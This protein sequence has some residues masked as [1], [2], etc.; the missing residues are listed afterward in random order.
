[1][2]STNNFTQK[3]LEGGKLKTKAKKD[4]G[5]LQ[6]F[7]STGRTNL[8]CLWEQNF[9]PYQ[10]AIQKGKIKKRSKSLN[11]VIEFECRIWVRLSSNPP[12]NR[13]RIY[14]IYTTPMSSSK[15]N[16]SV[17]RSDANEGKIMKLTFKKQNKSIS[18]FITNTLRID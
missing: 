3:R 16:S 7:L 6:N 1:M 17:D 12:Q 5:S 14:Y 11:N 9:P 4:R 15:N 8:P 2:H 10:F 18:F 13:R